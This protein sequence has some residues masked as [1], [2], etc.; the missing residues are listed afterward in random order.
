ML[1]DGYEAKIV[2]DFL[3]IEYQYMHKRHEI[4]QD[5]FRSLASYSPAFGMIGTLIGL[6]KM[7]AN[8]SDPS[9][10]GPPMATALVTTFYGSLMANL[11]F[12][13]ISKKLK[14][15]TE[16]EGLILSILIEGIFSIQDGVN[17]RIVR[18]KLNAFLSPS[19]RTSDED[20][21]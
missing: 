14:A 6:I 15:R 17:P 8:L 2:K 7:L 11:F 19:L 4:G 13:P 9:K 21:E 5:I 3:T 20:D 10:L 1:I 18:R 16:E 12:L